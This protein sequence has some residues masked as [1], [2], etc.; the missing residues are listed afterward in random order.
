MTPELTRE[1]VSDRFL[2]KA[3]PAF[4]QT[5]ID[6]AYQSRFSG[7]LYVV[8]L[9][10]KTHG[11]Q[12]GG[13]SLWG[14]SEALSYSPS[15]GSGVI[16]APKGFV[17][18]LA[19]I[20]RLFWAL[21]PPD[22]PWVKAAV[23]HDFLYYTQGTGIWKGHPR[24]ITKQGDYTRA[25]ADWVLRDAMEDRGVDGVRRNIIYEAVRL[26]GGGGWGH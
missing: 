14:L 11:A 17:T 12:R 1:E 21:L 22:G 26:G 5:A 15:D 4:A 10:D 24:S 13:R 8:L 19:S 20:P 18:D 2:G 7:K 9:D 23:V 16:T 25:Q 6:G 3:G